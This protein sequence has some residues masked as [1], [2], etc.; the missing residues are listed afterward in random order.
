MLDPKTKIVMDSSLE[1]VSH[2]FKEL[3]VLI[4]KLLSQEGCPWDKEQTLQS[5]KPFLIEES[6]EVLDAI[7]KNDIKE[8]CEELGDVLFQ[9]VFQ[10]ALRENQNEFDILQVCQQVVKKMKRRHPHIFGEVQVHSSEEVKANWEVLKKQEQLETGK[11]RKTLGGIPQSLPALLYAEKLGEKAAKV[12]FDW[13]FVKDIREKVNEE[14]H[15]LDEAISS[16]DRQAMIH[17]MGDVLVTL[18]RLAKKLG[19]SAEESLRIANTRFEKR[20][21]GMEQLAQEEGYELKNMTLEEM[22]KY[23]QKV[24]EYEKKALLENKNQ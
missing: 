18:S 20:F 17:E 13:S 11:I 12:G 23:W 9:I 8:H 16:E 14:I 22:D 15:E 1:Q 7:D 2:S 10:A 4:K 19:F 21:E 3:V 5:L 24:K 6:Y